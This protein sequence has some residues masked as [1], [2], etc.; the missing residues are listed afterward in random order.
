M[1]QYRACSP[2][3]N[4]HRNENSLVNFDNYL[5]M[6][7]LGHLDGI[8]SDSIVLNVYLCSIYWLLECFA[9]PINAGY[10]PS[11]LE[12]SRVT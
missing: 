2:T 8:F 10:E 12:S 1:H 7:S 6:I 11:G 5:S 3:I 4:L 9:Y